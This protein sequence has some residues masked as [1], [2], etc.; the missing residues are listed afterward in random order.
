MQEYFRTIQSCYE[1]V[2]SFTRDIYFSITYFVAKA[3]GIIFWKSLYKRRQ[4]TIDSIVKHLQIPVQEAIP[5]ARKS[6]IENFQSF[7]ECFLIPFFGFH[8]QGLCVERPDVLQSM[9]DI[10]R[11]IVATTG[12]F[13]SWELLAA[14]IGE[15]S[16]RKPRAIVVRKYK[17]K[18]IQ[19]FT[20][21][22]RSSKGATILGHR[23]ATFSVL[24]ILKKAGV[25]AFLVD[26]NTHQ[27]EAF[28]LPFLGETAAVNKGPA[29]LAVRA[30]ALVLPVFLERRK[31]QY[32]L[33]VEEPLDT[34]ILKGNMEEK[35]FIVAKYYTEA[36]EKMVCQSPEQWFWMHNR[37]KTQ[38]EESKN[39]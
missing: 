13:G 6:F 15:F 25:V 3:W 2:S 27:D 10:D 26:H 23:R 29:I 16:D 34:A 20:L 37:W 17:N 7:F 38:P 8:H 9:Q 21:R 31:N 36:V 1:Y 5:L 33:W 22:L 14:L 39:F 32:I 11:P 19:F 18:V 24:R 35:A 12:H 28:F 4:Q 30:K